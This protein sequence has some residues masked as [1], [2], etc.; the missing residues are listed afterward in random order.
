[1]SSV[2]YDESHP[3]FRSTGYTMWRAPAGSH[4]L[5]VVDGYD[6]GAIEAAEQVFLRCKCVR[7]ARPGGRRPFRF[8]FAFSARDPM[9]CSMEGMLSSLLFSYFAKHGADAADEY[10]NLINDQLSLH[11]A[12]TE[13]DLF[14]M[15]I[16]LAPIIV[17]ADTLLLLQDVEHCSQPSRE[18]FWRVLDALAF[19]TE[20]PFKL[21]ITSGRSIDI[22]HE[23]LRMPNLLTTTYAAP[24]RTCW[25]KT[26]NSYTDEM[27]SFLCPGGYGETQVRSRMKLLAAKKPQDLHDVLDLITNISSWPREPSAEAFHRF[28]CHLNA[29]TLLSKPADVL[30]KALRD[31]A[32]Q[33]GLRWALNW[34][35]HAQRPLAYDE[36]AMALC[37]HKPAGQ[38]QTFHTPPLAAVRQSLTQLQT[39]FRGI[40]ESCSGQARFRQIVRDCIQEGSNYIWAE[41]A[42][43]DAISTFLVNYLT[44]PEIQERLDTI[45]SQYESLLQSSRDGITP[46][47][48]PDGQDIIF[49]AIEALPHHVSR[50]AS[51]LRLLGGD[52]WAIEGRLA[53][54]LRAYWAMSNPFSRPKFG[55]LKTPNQILSLLRNLIRAPKGVAFPKDALKPETGEML[56]GYLRVPLMDSLACAIRAGDEDSALSLASTPRVAARGYEEGNGDSAVSGNCA[57]GPETPLFAA[58]RHGNWRVVDQLLQLGSDANAGIKAE[59]NDARRAPLAVASE[60]GHLKTARILLDHGADPNIGGGPGNQSTPLWFAAVKAGNA[61]MASLLLK[62]GADPSHELLASSPLLIDMIASP[63]STGDKLEMLDVLTRDRSLNLFNVADRNGMTPLLHAAAAG[64][65]DIVQWLLN[66]EADVDARDSRGCCA[67]YYA[68]VNKHERLVRDLLARKPQVNVTTNDGQT[69]LEAAMEQV[70]MVRL[71]LDAG[72]DAELGN[73]RGRTAIIVAV[74]ERRTDVVKLLLERKASVHHRDKD[75]FSPIL[76]ATA[77]STDAEIVRILLE[78]GANLNDAHPATGDTPLHL[79]VAIDAGIARMLLEHGE[80]VDYLEKRDAVSRTPLLAAA[81]WGKMD[82]V[83]LLVRAGADVNA[84]DD[85]G[86]TVLSLVSTDLSAAALEA[87]DLLLSQPKMMIDTKGKALGTALMMACRSLN[88]RMVTKL[89]A[90]GADPNISIMGPYSTAIAATCFP[91]DGVKDENMAKTDGIIRELIAHGANVNTTGGNSIFN[92]ICAASFS[93]GASTVELLLGQG[94]SVHIPDP[95]GRLPIHF[96]AASGIKNFEA[97][98]SVYQGDLMMCDNAGKN[99]LHWAAQF[100]HVET[101]KAILGRLDSL[102]RDRKEYINRGDIDGWTPLCWATRPFGQDLEP[103]RASEPGSYVATVRCL[104][105]QGA[106]PHVKL[107]MGK[108]MVAERFTPA[109]MAKL[110]DAEDEVVSLLGG[111]GASSESS[112]SAASGDTSNPLHPYVPRDWFCDICQTTIFGHSFRCQ[113]CY[114]FDVCKKCFGNIDMYHDRVVSDDCEQ[115]F[116]QHFFEIREGCEQEFE[117]CMATPSFFNSYVGGEFADE[118][119]D[120]GFGDYLLGDWESVEMPVIDDC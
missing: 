32:D 36:L 70:S 16:T 81:S 51:A 72:A 74:L 56:Q 23:L 96:A 43:S 33:D 77:H 9:R 22:G 7:A 52:L 30:D 35:L 87:C 106:N 58:S 42:A 80:A 94:A 53:P 117:G 100:G 116:G 89:L 60:Y 28:T 101:I 57:R 64:D 27:I 54:W 18:R 46:P 111:D 68:L 40:A 14:N 2:R 120:G 59:I 109:Q 50:S 3:V 66:H 69:L 10:R 21:V 4:V 25:D 114:D 6:R 19:T 41:P 73:K 11:Q 102:G 55:T 62:N 37:Y 29:V 17:N 63:A 103:N 93:A 98:A 92:A 99:V 84:Q 39:W 49:Y 8:S 26:P 71:L 12:W 75:G 108:G 20:A 1:M 118:L 67:L 104:L 115:H 44:S 47:L 105:G 79:A 38:G 65:L 45:Y 78:G 113:C 91:L 97:V 112:W 82:C 85:W 86:W 88:H 31:V 5:Y 48:V 95:L 83:D 13:T 24:G 110:C 34:L 76:I 15:F 119:E 90:H 61:T 107:H